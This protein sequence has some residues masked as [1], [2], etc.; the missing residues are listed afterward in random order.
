MGE[1]ETILRLCQIARDQAD[2]IERQAEIIA[3]YKIA[4]S[5][6][7]GLAEKGTATAASLAAI[8]KEYN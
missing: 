7:A 3:Q 6:A 2:I 5:V 4:D 1:Y 8:E